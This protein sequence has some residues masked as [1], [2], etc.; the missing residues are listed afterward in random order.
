MKPWLQGPQNLPVK[1]LQPD[2]LRA[3]TQPWITTYIETGTFWGYQLRFASEVF[4]KVVGIEIDEECVKRSRE[5]NADRPNVEVIHG[6]TLD[7]LP[8]LVLDIEDPC[9]FYLD[10][11]YCNHPDQPLEPSTFPLWTELEY[12]RDRCMAD[13]VFIDD[14]H[15]FGKGYPGAEE[16]VTVTTGSIAKFF[17]TEKWKIVKD[18][19]VVWL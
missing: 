14:F 18:G 8:R 7:V 1:R 12:I 3:L 15:E 9:F 11:H 2:D 10:A 13:V 5:W 16:W 17:K 6:D 4:E 19:M